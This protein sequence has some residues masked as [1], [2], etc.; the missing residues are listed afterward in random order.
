[1]SCTPQKTSTRPA[2]D[3]ADFDPSCN[4]C[5]CFLFQFII[6]KMAQDSVSVHH[7]DVRTVFTCAISVGFLVKP[8]NINW[9]RWLSSHQMTKSVMI[10]SSQLWCLTSSP[11]WMCLLPSAGGSLTSC[12]TG[13]SMWDWLCMSQTF[14]ASASVAFRALYFIPCSSPFTPT[15][16]SL[17]TS[18]SNSRTLQMTPHSPGS[19]QVEMNLAMGGTL[20]TWWPGAVTTALWQNSVSGL[21]V[22]TCP[23]SS[24][25]PACLP[26]GAI[27]F[28][29]LM[30]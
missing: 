24:H 21:Q 20:T 27:I 22:N 6:K 19:S 5:D 3:W 11:R 10:L 4:C 29:D 23:T 12:L 15:A 18:L 7:L 30:W 13:S 9:C 2:D 16:A 1:M 25:L 28:Q 26:S 8:T 17:D 14:S